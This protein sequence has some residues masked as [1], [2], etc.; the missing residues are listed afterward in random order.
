MA[1]VVADDTAEIRPVRLGAAVGSRFEV[2]DALEPGDVVVVRG[3]ERLRPGQKVRALQTDTPAPPTVEE[4]PSNERAPSTT[5]VPP[6]AKVP[7]SANVPKGA[8]V[9]VGAEG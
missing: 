7:P 5:T 2:L 4:A 3:N 8:K 6:S 9:R 1:V